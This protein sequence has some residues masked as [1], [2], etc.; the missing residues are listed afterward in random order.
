MPIEKLIQSMKPETPLQIDS[1]SGTFGAASS[2]SAAA[3]PQ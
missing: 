3:G 2:T 1:A